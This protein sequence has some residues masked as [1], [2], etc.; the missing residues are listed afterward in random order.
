MLDSNAQVLTAE[1]Q[2]EIISYLPDYENKEILEL[3]AGIG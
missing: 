3:G 1:E 2:N